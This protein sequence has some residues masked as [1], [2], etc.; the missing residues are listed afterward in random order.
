MIFGQTTPMD[1]DR[2]CKFQ[3]FCPARS[4]CYNI[5]HGILSC[6]KLQGAFIL[7]TDKIW[8][9]QLKYFSY[10]RDQRRAF[11]DLNLHIKTH[12]FVRKNSQNAGVNRAK[13]AYQCIVYR[14]M[15][16]PIALNPRV[17]L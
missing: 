12:Q 14:P 11:S 5:A 13:K 2:K 3:R 6:Y 8:K 10:K 17:Y 7:F 15:R 4:D 9:I 16:S 1:S